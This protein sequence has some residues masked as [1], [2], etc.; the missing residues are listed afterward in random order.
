M[1]DITLSFLGGPPPFFAAPP[2]ELGVFLRA[3]TPP[4]LPWLSITFPS[5]P[6]LAGTP[7]GPDGL[8]YALTAGRDVGLF[9]SDRLAGLPGLWGRLRELKQK[10]V[11]H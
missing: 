7:A 4:P 5:P 2:P 3:P 8:L 10:E 1:T 9:S 6:A 11:Y